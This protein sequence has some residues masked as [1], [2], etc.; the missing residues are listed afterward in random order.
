MTMDIAVTG[1]SVRLPA[2]DTPWQ[3]HRL[4]AKA[5]SAIKRFGVERPG[6]I[7]ARGLIDRHN[8]F[9]TQRFRLAEAEA[10][11]MDPQHRLVL[12]EAVRAM[13]SA[14]HVVGCRA[15]D[16][17]VFASCSA[18]FNHW[19]S[20]LEDEADNS[21]ARYN[22]LLSNDKDFLATRI[23]WHLDLTGPA[24]SVQ[25]GCSSSLVALHQACQALQQGD[26]A[27]ALAA[28][29]SLTLP[30]EESSPVSEGM[31]FSPSGSCNPY[32]DKADG[33]VGGTG[34][35]VLVLQPLDEALKEGAPCW[36]IIKGSAINNDGRKKVSFTAPSIDQQIAVIK[37][38]LTKAD[39]NPAKVGF[40]E[41]HGTGTSMGDS[42]ELAALMEVYGRQPLLPPLGSIK[43]NIG[44]L[45]AASGLAGV[46]KC[47]LSLHNRVIYPQPHLGDAQPQALFPLPAQ[48]SP[49][50]EPDQLAAVTS[51]GV[52]GTNVHMVIA[53]PPARQVVSLDGP[54]WMP[55]A[56]DSEDGLRLLARQL[57]EATERGDGGALSHYARTLQHRY[58]QGDQRYRCNMQ[59]DSWDHWRQ[60]LE[61]IA[62]GAPLPELH[63][64]APPPVL[65]ASPGLY[66]VALPATPLNSR[67]LHLEEVRA[68]AESRP[69]VKTAEDS[70]E[71]LITAAW[72]KCLG[73]SQKP[74]ANA[75]FFEE[76][77]NSLLSVQLIQ[78]LKQKGGLNVSVADLYEAPQLGSFI[79]RLTR[80]SCEVD[81]MD[82]TTDD[83]FWEL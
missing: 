7:G 42:I 80:K 68:K 12:E 60:Q 30:L 52:G 47:L 17:G 26:C 19:Q 65:G 32:T 43:A 2:S 41:G 45:D 6:W 61:Q 72:Q 22:I 81:A 5:G 55:L 69:S 53:P 77:G 83:N 36:G 67:C 27:I 1:M 59:V 74:S 33:T 79:R 38:A 49:W 8:W 66:R 50:R 14:G 23:A 10:R 25:S 3:L 56:A 35:V 34:V 46:A 11:R 58:Q 39:V 28:G 9:D 24:M 31:I 51:L 70:S 4:L 54:F 37:H 76:G 82:G 21:I 16:C 63:C 20:C 48:L 64:Q 62:G 75:H 44:H 15:L 78:E 71:A 29:A 40:I 73:F 13:E 18:S 57:L